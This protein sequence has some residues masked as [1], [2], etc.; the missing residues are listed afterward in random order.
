M[1]C[2]PTE[3]LPLRVLSKGSSPTK[4]KA[5]ACTICEL[6]SPDLVHTTASL[7]EAPLWTR[8]GSRQCFAP[9]LMIKEEARPAI[10]GL[11][12]TFAGH[13]IAMSPLART[14]SSTD[15]IRSVPRFN[16]GLSRQT[17]AA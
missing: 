11:L 12:L 13:T 14:G 17:T 15:T 4:K 2:G 1:W 5:N 9:R 16:D 7:H 3:D 8:S 10:A 6:L